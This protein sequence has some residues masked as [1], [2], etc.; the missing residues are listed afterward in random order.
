M[1][2]QRSPSGAPPPTDAETIRQ[3]A[4][5]KAAKTTSEADARLA[6]AQAQANAIIQSAN[7]KAEDIAGDALTALRDARDLERTVE[8]LD[9][10]IK[11]YGD[12]YIV[13]THSRPEAQAS[14]RARTRGGANEQGRRM[15]LRRS[16]PP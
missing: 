11:G 16:E 13:P 9:N 8:A 3:D 12:A 5:L 2:K 6:D 14:A 7:Q 15:R 1:T 10:V 4:R